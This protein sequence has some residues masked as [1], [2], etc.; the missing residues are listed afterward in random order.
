MKNMQN[1]MC[2]KCK[3]RPGEVFMTSIINNKRIEELLCLECAM[4]KEEVMFLSKQDSGFKQFLSQAL[5]MRQLSM[6]Q[7]FTRL[8]E[9]KPEQKY[10][11]VIKD[12]C[13]VCGAN[14]DIIKNT[15]M[16]GCS[17]CYNTFE[18]DIDELMDFSSGG[19]Y[20]GKI[21]KSSQAAFSAE[22]QLFILKERLQESIKK[23]EYE[24]ADLIKEQISQLQKTR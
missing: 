11:L 24:K 22:R 16:V 18:R 23:E 9:I 6:P 7:E 2:S 1:M 20:S 19:V 4:Q 8:S 3:Q 14:W 5:Q 15:G 12:D 21:P 10:E 17:N 13:E